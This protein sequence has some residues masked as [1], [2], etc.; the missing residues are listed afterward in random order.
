MQPWLSAI[1]EP[2][3][4]RL[5]TCYYP[6]LHGSQVD[7]HVHVVAEVVPN[8]G[9]DAVGAADGSTSGISIILDDQ[10]ARFAVR[11]PHVGVVHQVVGGA[12]Q[13]KQTIFGDIRTPNWRFRG[14]NI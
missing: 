8:D 3:S 1:T 11:V 10:Q 7:G 12:H 2:K 6:P 14:G 5:P 13:W 9:E 4:Q